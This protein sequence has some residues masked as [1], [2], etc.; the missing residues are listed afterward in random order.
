MKRQQRFRPDEIVIAWQP[1]SGDHDGIPYVIQRG[2]RLRASSPA[3]VA[4][5]D[6]FVPDGTPESEWPTIWEEVSRVIA[7]ERDR[8]A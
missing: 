5:P 2:M 7:A 1:F 6:N 3:V 8:A 4:C